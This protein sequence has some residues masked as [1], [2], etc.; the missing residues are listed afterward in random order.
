MCLCSRIYLPVVFPW[1]EAWVGEDTVTVTEPLRIIRKPP[2]QSPTAHRCVPMELQHG[3][4]SLRIQPQQLRSWE[5]EEE[6]D[7]DKDKD[8]ITS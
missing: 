5:E 4:S 6:E 2:Q 1:G 8:D 3:V 7:E